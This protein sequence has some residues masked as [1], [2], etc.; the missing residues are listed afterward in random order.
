MQSTNKNPQMIKI[1]LVGLHTTFT[2][3]KILS[4]FR[5]KFS[6]VTKCKLIT[7][8]NKK[9]QFQNT[10]YGTLFVSSEETYDKVIDEGN[11]ILEGRRFFS[12]PFMEGNQL[13]QFKASI[14]NRRAFLH[15]IDP[16]LDNRALRNIMRAHAKIEDA[17]II[18][19]RGGNKDPSKPNFGFVMFKEVRD[20]RRL[21]ATREIHYNGGRFY[22]SEYKNEDERKNETVSFLKKSPVV[23]RP[24]MVKNN[25]PIKKSAIEEFRDMFSNRFEHHCTTLKEIAAN[26]EVS[27]DLRQEY[28]EFMYINRVDSRRGKSFREFEHGRNN[29]RMNNGPTT[30]HSRYNQYYY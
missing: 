18:N 15:N 20:A 10:G 3:E 6:C 21:I 14:K 24:D 13:H 7:K 27:K 29:L 9:G 12:K 8:I 17:Y 2:Q 22:I 11:F 4:F 16:K 1:F 30:S 26:P 19:R 28:H 25:Y 5:S 23:P